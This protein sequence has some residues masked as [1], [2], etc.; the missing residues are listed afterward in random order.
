MVYD[1]VLLFFYVFNKSLCFWFW[2]LV[3]NLPV[4]FTKI[5]GI[6][7]KHEKIILMDK[8]GVKRLTRLV[9][10]GPNYGRRGLGKGWK[11]FCEANDVLKIGEP[12]TLKLTWENNTPLLRFCSKVKEEPIYVWILLLA[13]VLLFSLLSLEEQ[14]N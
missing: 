7:R 6:T 13:Q 12:F 11:L 9:H 1:Y 2:N 14:S 3:Q 5:N 4:E 10:D 8:H